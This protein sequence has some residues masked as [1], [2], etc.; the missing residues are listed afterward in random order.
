MGDPQQPSLPSEEERA[1]LAY[2]V[3][4]LFQRWGL[5]DSQKLVLLGLSRRDK[6]RLE[7]HK[8]GRPLDPEPATLG[9]ASGLLTLH[10]RLADR[11]PGDD[12]PRTYTWVVEPHPD[13]DDRRPLDVMLEDGVAGIRRVLELAQSEPS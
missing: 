10:Q 8:K 9:R 11:F 2:M 3:L 13:L 12:D 6:K 1:Q 4:A 7:A 5:E